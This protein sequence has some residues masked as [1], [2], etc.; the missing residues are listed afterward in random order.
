MALLIRSNGYM[1][2]FIVGAYVDYAIVPF[3]YMGLPIIFFAF[4]MILPNTAPYLIR[5][6]LH[7]VSQMNT[8]I[9]IYELTTLF[10]LGSEKLDKTLQRIHGWNS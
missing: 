7:D 1:I 2:A 6:G 8:K 4:L 10:P 5:T 9:R 3:I